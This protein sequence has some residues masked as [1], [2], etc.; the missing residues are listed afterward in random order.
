[1][2]NS[3]KENWFS[4]IDEQLGLPTNVEP[5]HYTVTLKPNLNDFTFDGEVLIDIEV[6]FRQKCLL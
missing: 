4:A 2:M 1:M 3:L 6:N 5:N